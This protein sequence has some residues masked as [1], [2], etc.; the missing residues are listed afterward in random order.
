MKPQG[1]LWVAYPCTSCSPSRVTQVKNSELWNP[2]LQGVGNLH[3]KPL[4]SRGAY[5]KHFDR[6]VFCYSQKNE[7]RWEIIMNSADEF[8]QLNVY[9][10]IAV[11]DK[12]N[13]KTII[14]T[15]TPTVDN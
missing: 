2:G 3:S 13:S 4:F 5:S 10:D 8:C 12:I 1:G 7:R 15:F 14:S 6:L 11:I 9:D